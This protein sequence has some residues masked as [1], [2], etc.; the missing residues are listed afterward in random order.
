MNNEW[1]LKPQADGGYLVQSYWFGHWIT[2]AA[3]KD[4]EE[5]RRIIGNLNRGTIY[6][7]S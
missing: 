4:E 7:N 6:V 5:G 1:R 3:A 2:K